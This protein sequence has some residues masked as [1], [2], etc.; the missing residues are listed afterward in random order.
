MPSPVEVLTHFEAQSLALSQKGYGGRHLNRC[1]LA[2]AANLY[3]R[4]HCSKLVLLV[5]RSGT[6][7]FLTNEL[8]SCR[9]PLLPAPVPCQC[10]RPATID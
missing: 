1:S 7:I 5:S 2:P 9:S 4:L 10:A 6:A 3:Q 8:D